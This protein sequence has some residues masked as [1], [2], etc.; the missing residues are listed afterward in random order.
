MLNELLNKHPLF[1]GLTSHE[2]SNLAVHYHFIEKKYKKNE[3]ILIEGDFVD[4]I[5]IIILKSTRYD[6]CM[7]RNFG[8]TVFISNII[9]NQRGNLRPVADLKQAA[10][11]ELSVIAQDIFLLGM[12]NDRSIQKGI[13][14]GRRGG[15]C[16]IV[17]AIGADKAEINVNIINH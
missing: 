17:E 10:S 1:I 12:G 2:I 7:F 11:L 5:G 4:F 8:N 15:T 9:S 6:C 3:Y 14:G 16:H 13:R